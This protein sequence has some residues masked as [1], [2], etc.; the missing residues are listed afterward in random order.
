MEHWCWSYV[1]FI[2]MNSV[3]IRIMINNHAILTYEATLE[4]NMVEPA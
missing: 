1:F 4:S 2:D 3:G